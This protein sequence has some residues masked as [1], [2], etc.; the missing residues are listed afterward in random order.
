MPK[1]PLD[2]AV[3]VQ[4]QTNHL[5]IRNLCQKD[6][7]TEQFTSKQNRPLKNEHLRQK[8]KQ[9]YMT[10]TNIQSHNV[11]TYVFHMLRTY[12]MILCN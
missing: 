11:R 7:L 3:Y 12:V 5:R 2:R 4:T 10:H 1:G 8:H 9:S 6:H